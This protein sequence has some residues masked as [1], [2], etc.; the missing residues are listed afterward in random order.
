MTLKGKLGS[1]ISACN[2]LSIF[3]FN[4]QDISVKLLVKSLL[5]G[6]EGEKNKGKTL[7]PH[8]TAQL[9][10]NLP[11]ELNLDAATTHCL[12]FHWGSLTSS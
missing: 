8:G 11:I 3:I 5:R 7:Q 6:K 4:H 1:F 12:G 10:S 9:L 2:E